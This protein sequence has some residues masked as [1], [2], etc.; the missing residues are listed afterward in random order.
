DGKQTTDFGGSESGADVAI[1]ADGKIVVAG[2][3][4]FAGKPSFAIARYNVNGTPD[5]DF[6]TDG[7]TSTTLNGNSFASG[8]ALQ[9]NG[10]I[11]VAGAVVFSFGSSN[12]ALIRYT[13]NGAL[14]TSFGPNN[15]GITFADFSEGGEDQARDLAL[16]SDG[17]IVAAGYE[18]SFNNNS[19]NFAVARFNPNG[20]LDSSFGSGGKV[21]TIFG[22]FDGDFSA[23]INGVALQ[24]NSGIVGAGSTRDNQFNTSDVVLA[25]YLVCLG[26]PAKPVLVKPKNDG[27]VKTQT[28]LLDWKN[29]RCATKYSVT[30]RIGSPTGTKVFTK[31]DF[32]ASEARVTTPLTSGQKYFWRVT[33]SN[34]AGS[35]ISDARSFQVE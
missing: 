7:R 5:N 19:A 9:S 2:S 22:A 24:K 1:Q 13:S 4:D 12:F 3:R 21:S 17:K 33:A 18:G 20:T 34:Q 11:V 31:E 6:D 30:V 25:R 23:G 32:T 8:I 27:V 35:T 28:P 10:K 26:K 15:N 16:Q 14:D 29:A